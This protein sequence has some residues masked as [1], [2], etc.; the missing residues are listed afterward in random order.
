MKRT[1]FLTALCLQYFTNTLLAQENKDNTLI[2]DDRKN[3]V[4]GVYLGIGGEIGEVDNETAYIGNVKLAYVAN[5]Q[6]EV[7]FAGKFAYWEQNL[8]ANGQRIEEDMYAA[9]GG[10][11]IEPIFFSKSLISLSLP[12]LL[13]GGAVGYLDNGSDPFSLEDRHDA[14]FV[15]E[16]G[17]NLL[18]NVSRFLQIEAGVSYRFSS[19]VD[20]G[21]QGPDN[22]NGPSAGIGVKL[23][24]FDLGRNKNKRLP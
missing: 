14:I 23:G 20:L 19:K 1:I 16:P 10:L 21:P 2:F 3:I 15:V 12:V 9:Y 18:F 6:L 5:R 22:I 24:I 7:G 4:H 11:H 13:G 8:N 17:A